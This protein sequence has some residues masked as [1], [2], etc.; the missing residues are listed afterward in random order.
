MKETHTKNMADGPQL[1]SFG[2][3]TFYYG[4]Y[5]ILTFTEQD[6]GKVLN[7]TV[8]SVQ[9]I[10]WV[11]L[12]PAVYDGN[13]WVGWTTERGQDP[14]VRTGN[15]PHPNPSLTW[16]I[17]PGNYTLYFVNSGTKRQAGQETV[18]YHIEVVE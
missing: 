13:D 4:A 10:C 7:V 17:E 18:T 9:P 16:I 15:K 2:S 8:D 11:E 14:L 5:H 1:Y 6:Q 3:K 12:W